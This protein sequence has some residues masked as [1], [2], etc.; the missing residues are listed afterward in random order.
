MWKLYEG[1]AKSGIRS[2]INQYRLDS[3]KDASVQSHWNSLN[4]LTQA[5]AVSSKPYLI[6]KDMIQ[7]SISKMKNAKATGQSGVEPEMER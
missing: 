4:S 5:D 1:S 6:E 3:Q 2:Y 7:E